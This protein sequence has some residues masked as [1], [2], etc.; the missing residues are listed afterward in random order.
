MSTVPVAPTVIDRCEVLVASP[1]R[2]FVTLRLTTR[3]GLVGLGDGTLNGREL[4]VATYL[5]EH[6]APLLAGR[7]A[8]AIE[9]T[10]QYLYRGAYWR[11]GSVTMAAI[12]AVDTALW[13]IKG[14]LAGLP[15][16]QLLGGASRCGLLAYAHASGQN[17]EELAEMVGHYVQVGYR[18]VRLQIAVPGMERV[19]G[20]PAFPGAAY[21]PA[22]R[23]PL[24]VEETWDARAYL[25]HVPGVLA[26]IR[27]RVGAGLHLLHDAHHRLTPIEAARLARELE[28]V[29]LFWLED[30]TAAERQAALR[31]V[32]RHSVTPLAIGEVFNTVWDCQQLI[33]ERLID[34]LR[35]CV[36]HAGGI[37]HLR[38]ALTFA[39][40]HGV[41]SGM[42]GAT[43]ISP[44]GMA[45]ALHL[46]LSIPNFGI[47]EHVAHTQL[48]EAAFPHAYRFEDGYL[49]PG[50]A[51]GLGVE[52]NDAVLSEHPYQ[53]AYLPVARRV[54]GT[55]H[56]W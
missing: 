28:P 17:I 4:A 40:L 7:D 10:W 21:E 47:Q 52:L 12:A 2:N 43:D 5:Q 9:D 54:D 38:K 8:Q 26:E 44:V 39:E 41:R 19:Y 18:A 36:T 24:P 16:Y 25:A 11:R 27:Q 48:T 30:V 3:E 6:V 35:M 55:M 46:G 45:A 37:T 1:G 33:A 20:V 56:D 34:Y 50:D 22:L 13:D 53:P 32:R 51:A 23:T 29:D 31:L 49:H 15:V 14:K 42:H